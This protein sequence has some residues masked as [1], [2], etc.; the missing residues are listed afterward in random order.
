MTT[1]EQK[2]IAILRANGLSQ[3]QIASELNL[4]VNAV[5]AWCR[6]HPVD[7][8]P[9][10]VCLT[11]GVPIAQNPKRKMKKF[12]SDKCRYAWWSRH[13][14]ERSLKKAYH[15]ICRCCGEEFDSNRPQSIFC[16]RLCY[17]KYRCK[18]ASH[19]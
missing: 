10:T 5:K 11:C 12:C 7:T 14:E 18:E 8:T 19:D 4:N 13:P 2:Q 1:D 15:H 9:K 17:G 3:S 6:R 16:S